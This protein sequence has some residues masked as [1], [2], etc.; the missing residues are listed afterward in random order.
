MSTDYQSDE[1]QIEAIKKWWKENGKS[2]VTGIA[3][4]LAAVFG[5]QG[6]Q[7]QQQE[8]NYAASAAYQNLLNVVAKDQAPLN[9]E[10]IAS[11]NYLADILKNDYSATAYAQ[12]AALY[13]AQL[14]VKAGKLTDAEAELRWVLS[15]SPVEEVKAQAHLRLAKVLLASEKYDLA[16]AELA[17]PASAYKPLYTELKG[18]IYLAQG[19]VSAA[20]DAYLQAKTLATATANASANNLLELKIQQLKVAEGV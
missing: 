5:W 17:Q 13:K 8:T 15:Q 9:D 16:L 12:F 18:D 14:A 7:K 4:A 10:Q 2:T 1:E 20:R 19:D 6:W 11:A 3:L